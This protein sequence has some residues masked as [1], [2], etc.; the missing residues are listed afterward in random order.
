MLWTWFFNL[1]RFGRHPYIHAGLISAHSRSVYGENH[2]L[3]RRLHSGGLGGS[4][5]VKPE[6]FGAETGDPD[7]ETHNTGWVDRWHWGSL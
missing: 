3:A 1:Y 6:A 5:R 4:S 2:A 7:S